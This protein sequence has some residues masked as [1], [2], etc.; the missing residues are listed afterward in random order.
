[1]SFRTAAFSDGKW[2]GSWTIFYWAWWV[3]WAP[4][5]GVFIARIS[6]GRT[7]REFV[8]GVL[9]IPSSESAAATI[10]APGPLAVIDHRA[11]GR[12]PSLCPD[13]M[14]RK[15]GIGDQRGA[16]GTAEN[17][18]R[19]LDWKEVINLYFLLKWVCPLPVNYE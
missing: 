5:V 6:R 9:L 17:S 18:G 4:F 12:G 10:P 11:T 8:I 13:V 15:M 1:M 14:C 2:L 3:S 16:W 19:K 7:I